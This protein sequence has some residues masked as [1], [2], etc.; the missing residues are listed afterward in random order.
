MKINDLVGEPNK[1]ILNVFFNKKQK[2]NKNLFY[3][4]V[5][6]SLVEDK[7]KY[8]F[9]TLIFSSNSFNH[10]KRFIKLKKKFKRKEIYF[11]FINKKSSLKNT[12]LVLLYL[13]FVIKKNPILFDKRYVN[14]LKPD[15]LY[16]IK[17]KSIYK[18]IL[19]YFFQRLKNIYYTFF[20]K[21][22]LVKLR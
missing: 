22:F 10:M 4:N 6:F 8:E 17:Y 12:I 11:I 19:F 18:S 15:F 21:F 7:K 2:L 1:K 16:K 3:K 5:L 13:I 20:C 9:K 14:S